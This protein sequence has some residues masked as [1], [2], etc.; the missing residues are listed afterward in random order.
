MGPASPEPAVIPGAVPDRVVMRGRVFVWAC[1]RCGRD[2]VAY[3]EPYA[4]L[5]LDWH[6]C[7]VTL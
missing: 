5:R 6:L 7:A 2:G 4:S 3:T 1:S